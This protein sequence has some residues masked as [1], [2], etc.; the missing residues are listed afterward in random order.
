M[1]EQPLG[2]LQAALLQRSIFT[3]NLQSQFDGADR[4]VEVGGLRCHQH[5]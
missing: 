4:T 5:L 2:D 1:L 3:G